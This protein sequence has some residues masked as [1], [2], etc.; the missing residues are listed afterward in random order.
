MKHLFAVLQ[1]AALVVAAVPACADE[2]HVMTSGAF[3][4]AYLKLVPQFERATGHKVV[5]SFGASMGGAADSIPKRLE[6]GEQTDVVILAS[7]A[8]DQL[9]REG[10]VERAT[11]VDLVRSSIGVAVRAGFPRPDIS[12]VEALR[13][14]LLQ[15]RSI[16]YS[17]SASGVY[18]S[19]ELLPLLGIAEQVKGKT[20]RVESS[21]VGTIVARGDA[22]IGFQQVSELLPIAGIEYVGPL[23]PEVQRVT[24]FSAGITSKPKSHNAAKALL[25]FLTSPEAVPAIVES[26]LE[27]VPVATALRRI[28]QHRSVPAPPR[29]GV[30]FRKAA[31]R[32]SRRATPQRLLNEKTLL[33]KSALPRN[34]Q[35][36]T[37]LGEDGVRYTDSRRAVI[38]YL[39]RMRSTARRR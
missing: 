2:L 37:D 39:V 38:N 12:S 9:I 17:A 22:E 15:A 28:Q 25:R 26:G 24:I 30:E 13:R 21:R 16:A 35:G 18:V 14:T 29:F 19:T 6:R 7:S 20:I 5:T 32:D 3:T 36:V 27:P 23:P 11:R 1:A 10:R 8:L 33:E 34:G 4:A 31:G